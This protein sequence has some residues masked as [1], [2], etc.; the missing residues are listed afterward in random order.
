MV[1]P[2]NWTTVEPPIL[3]ESG[4]IKFWN[5][6]R[7]NRK[8]FSFHRQY[9]TKKVEWSRSPYIMSGESNQNTF[10][11][12]KHTQ[13]LLKLWV[14]VR[15]AVATKLLVATF[16]TTLKIVWI[17]TFTF[18]HFPRQAQTALL[19]SINFKWRYNL[20]KSALSISA[21]FFKWNFWW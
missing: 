12:S 9:G 11:R 3:V 13:D 7:Q 18:F 2:L 5:I 6:H 10:I 16:E 8:F 1:E 20:L 15:R 14:L 4:V 17:Y 19:I 21:I